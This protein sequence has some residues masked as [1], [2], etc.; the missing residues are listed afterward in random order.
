MV[1]WEI[2]EEERIIP[3]FGQLF[4]FKLITYHIFIYRAKS[5]IFSCIIIRPWLIINN[6]NDPLYKFRLFLVILTI[7]LWISMCCL[8]FCIFGR[9]KSPHFEEWGCC[10]LKPLFTLRSSNGVRT[11]LKPKSYNF[12]YNCET[13]S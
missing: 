7:F 9:S 13:F 8:F 1:W 12:L 6:Y 4:L 5:G 10:L 11:D 2:I 3:E